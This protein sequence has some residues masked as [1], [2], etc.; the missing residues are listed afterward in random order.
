MNIEYKS[1]ANR[2]WILW[3]I[4]ITVFFTGNIFK[5]Y[6]LKDIPFVI[7]FFGILIILGVI[8]LVYNIKLLNYLKKN[9]YEKWEELTTIPGFGSGFSNGFRQFGFL[10]S[11]ETLEDPIVAKLK[12]GYRTIALLIIVHF[13]LI[14]IFFALSVI[15]HIKGFIIFRIF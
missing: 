12:N 6:L 14:P 13:F 8:N 2:Y 5:I 1:Y 11:N 15:L 3:I 7:F 9:H 4:L 10:F